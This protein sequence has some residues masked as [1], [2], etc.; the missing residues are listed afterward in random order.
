[1]IQTDTNPSE[2]HQA[3]YDRAIRD[4][5]ESTETEDAAGKESKT[6]IYVCTRSKIITREPPPRI[7][8]LLKL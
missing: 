7:H 5:H 3:L 2:L 8:K 1:M 4:Q 6:H